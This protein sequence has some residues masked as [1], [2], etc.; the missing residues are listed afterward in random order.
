M[1][2]NEPTKDDDYLETT[3]KREYEPE[4]DA[5]SES[6]SSEWVEELERALCKIK[7]WYEREKNNLPVD[8]REWLK[9]LISFTEKMI[10]ERSSSNVRVSDEPNNS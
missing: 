2:I 5:G 9:E 1:S 4:R 3:S 7:Q 10:S 6:R 8:A